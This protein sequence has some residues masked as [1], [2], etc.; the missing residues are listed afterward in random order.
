MKNDMPK[1]FFLTNQLVCMK[2][3]LNVRKLVK[4]H[5]MQEINC[6]VSYKQ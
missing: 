2:I 1:K 4:T 5:S 6:P 3:I